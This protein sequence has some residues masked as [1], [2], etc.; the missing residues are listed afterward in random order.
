[1]WSPLEIQIALLRKKTNLTAIA[2]KH[3]LSSSA[4]RV[5]LIKSF[6]SA[7]KIIAQEL[8]VPVEEVFPDRYN[9]I[10]RSA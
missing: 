3:G 4:C 10:Q 5:A 9:K 7:E 8:N 1:M 2:V 6:P